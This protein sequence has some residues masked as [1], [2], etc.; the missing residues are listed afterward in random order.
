MVP[1][2]LLKANDM[3]YSLPHPVWIRSISPVHP[4]RSSREKAVR[5][6]FFFIY[7]IVIRG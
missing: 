3:H 6:I 5:I 1:T 2:D 7:R 4:Y